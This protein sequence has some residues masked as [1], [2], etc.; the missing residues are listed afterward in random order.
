MFFHSLNLKN[1]FSILHQT[2]KM[3]T[4]TLAQNDELLKCLTR[5]GCADIYATAGA[6]WHIFGF[7]IN[8]AE[9]ATNNSPSNNV[10]SQDNAT[11]SPA[12]LNFVRPGTEAQIETVHEAATSSVCAE[13]SN[14][15]RT[16]REKRNDKRRPRSV[17]RTQ[18]SAPVPPP[19]NLPNPP[20]PVQNNTGSEFADFLNLVSTMFGNDFHVSMSNPTSGKTNKK[21]RR[22]N[23]YKK[24]G[25]YQ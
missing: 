1:T 23:Y 22:R 17:P 3:T 18:T 2:A 8:N 5:A 24:Q 11:L 12:V 6:I 13:P 15:V 10:A 21:H 7:N 14:E 16:H 25:S 20:Q 19:R 9:F 4:I